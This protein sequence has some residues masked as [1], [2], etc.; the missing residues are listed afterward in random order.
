MLKST[1]LKPA[2]VNVVNG[3]N[4]SV[5]GEMVDEYWAKMGLE[6]QP[7]NLL[8]VELTVTIKKGLGLAFLS[9]N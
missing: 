8:L 2:T 1:G 4:V 9:G 7:T 3:R 6:I 5:S